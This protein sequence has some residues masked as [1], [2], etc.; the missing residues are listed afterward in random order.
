ML[1]TARA[2]QDP[3]CGGEAVGTWQLF[4][5]VPSDWGKAVKYPLNPLYRLVEVYIE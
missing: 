3:N 5:I 4:P 1:P 2:L